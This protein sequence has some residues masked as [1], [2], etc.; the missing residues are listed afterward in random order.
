MI[1]QAWLSVV[2]RVLEETERIK[3]E[4]DFLLGKHFG[5]PST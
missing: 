4:R 1:E 2:D 3:K 5:I